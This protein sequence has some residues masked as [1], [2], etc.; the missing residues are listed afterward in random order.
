MVRVCLGTFLASADESSAARPTASFRG[1]VG[2]RSSWELAN[3][4]EYVALGEEIC[5]RST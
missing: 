1:P 3:L 2:D 4:A 5:V